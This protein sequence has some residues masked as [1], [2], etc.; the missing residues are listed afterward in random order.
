MLGKT[1]ERLKRAHL[2]GIDMDL[3]LLAAQYWGLPKQMPLY[4]G[5]R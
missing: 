1:E 3:T 4:L 5:I 2:A